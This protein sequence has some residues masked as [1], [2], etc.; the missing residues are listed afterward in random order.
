MTSATPFRSYH[1][2]GCKGAGK[3]TLLKLIGQDSLEKGKSVYLLKNFNDIDLV[4]FDIETVIDNKQ[5]TYFLIDETQENVGSTVFTLLL[6]ND[7]SRRRRP[8]V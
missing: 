3:T 4:R 7:V 8:C 2:S 1:T 5:E 6:K